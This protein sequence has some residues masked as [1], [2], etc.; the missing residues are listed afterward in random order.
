[1]HFH[2]AAL[3]TLVYGRKRWFMLSKYDAYNSR[4]AALHW[5]RGSRGGYDTL[6]KTEQLFEC[7]QQPGDVIYVPESWAH[8]VINVETSVGVAME[9]RKKRELLEL[10]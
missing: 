3:N 8:S 4:T 2:N 10:S 6:K 1:M 5:F 7:I 9:Y